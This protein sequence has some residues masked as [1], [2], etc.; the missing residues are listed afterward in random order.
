MFTRKDTAPARQALADIKPIEHGRDGAPHGMPPMAMA[1]ASE[2]PLSRPLESGAPAADPASRP[3]SNA[4]PVASFAAGSIIGSDLT[5]MGQGLRIITRGR[6]QIDG[7]V[8]GDVAGQEVIVGPHGHVVGMVSG[9]AVVVQGTV[10][11]TIKGL[12]VT[13]QAT[14]HVEG[15]VL[16]QTLVVEQG[17]HLDG[18]VRRPADLAELRPDLGAAA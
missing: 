11:G 9:E 1:R 5:I 16:H 15:D 3:A 7:R 6:L 8:E 14:S 10:S 17:A 2:T 13:L 4:A 18:R 12:S